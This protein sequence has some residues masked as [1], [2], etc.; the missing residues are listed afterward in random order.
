MPRRV[1]ALK[2]LREIRRGIFP[3]LECCLNLDRWPTVQ[4]QLYWRPYITHVTH[5]N[6][7]KTGNFCCQ[8]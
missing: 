1:R 6:R 5:G 4:S 8:T 7:E 3:S 2:K